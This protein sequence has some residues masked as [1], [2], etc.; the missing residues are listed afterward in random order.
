M[1]PIFISFRSHV[2]KKLAFH[3]SLKPLGEPH[4]W[5]QLGKTLSSDQARLCDQDEDEVAYNTKIVSL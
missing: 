2:P 3:C 4:R 1:F 5:S